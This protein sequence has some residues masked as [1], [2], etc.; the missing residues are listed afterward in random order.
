M[1]FGIDFHPFSLM[2]FCILI[3]LILINGMDDIKYMISPFFSSYNMAVEKVVFILGLTNTLG[4]FCFGFFYSRVMETV[5]SMVNLGFDARMGNLA[6]LSVLL[7]IL[8]NYI[9]MQVFSIPT[10]ETHSLIAGLTGSAIAI[11]GGL[12]GISFE[13][14]GKIILGIL[15]S[16]LISFFISYAVDLVIKKICKNKDRRKVRGFFDRGQFIAFFLNGFFHGAQN[17]QKFLALWALILNYRLFS[18]EKQWMSPSHIIF[19]GL[20]M[21]CGI[22]LGGKQLTR[23]FGVEQVLLENYESFSSGL[24]A[25]ITTLGALFLGIPLSTTH[26]AT[27]SVMGVGAA[28]RFTVINWSYAEQMALSWVLVFP[29]CGIFAYL[30]TKILLFL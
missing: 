17:G 22:Y 30:L 24:G 1:K 4:V 12:S 20:I 13:N 2:L 10:S 3:L 11:N 14:W 18:Q 29:S 27:A 16:S 7:T 21:F 5:F 28:K 6:L 15:F 9:V 25:S 23:K 26:T 19:V 8:L